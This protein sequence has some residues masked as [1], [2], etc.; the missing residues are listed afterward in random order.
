MAGGSDT[1]S[2]ECLVEGTV[3]LGSDELLGGEEE[4]G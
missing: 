2:Q 4:T 1:A 3:E